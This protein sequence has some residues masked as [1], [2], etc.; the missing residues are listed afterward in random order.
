MDVL[1]QGV[2]E[3]G[4]GGDVGRDVE[5]DVVAQEHPFIVTVDPEQDNN[6]WGAMATPKDSVMTVSYTHLD[7]YKR[8]YY[9]SGKSVGRCGKQ[10]K[11]FFSRG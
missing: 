3:V 1:A 2:L 11:V 7:V 9:C 4:P 8:Q 6:P 5:E 10:G